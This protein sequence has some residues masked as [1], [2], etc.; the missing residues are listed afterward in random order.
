MTAYT[1]DGSGLQGLAARLNPDATPD[2]LE[3]IVEQYW[4]DNQDVLYSKLS[5][6]VGTVVNI[7]D[8][9]T[10]K[11]VKKPLDYTPVPDSVDPKSVKPSDSAPVPESVDP[12]SVKSERGE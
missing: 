10:P 5:V 11:D 7:K 4:H 6:I 12:K 3:Q 8:D 2:E 1:L 9:A